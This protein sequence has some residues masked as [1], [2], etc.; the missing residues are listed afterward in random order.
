[1]S[2][3]VLILT[4]ITFIFSPLTPVLES[5]T[6]PFT[7]QN[8]YI[9]QDRDTQADVSYLNARYYKTN[10]GQFLSQDPVFW[11]IAQTEDGN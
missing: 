2:F 9:G 7:P 6:H 10:Q 5:L 11:E 8:Q 4:L 1:M 3:G